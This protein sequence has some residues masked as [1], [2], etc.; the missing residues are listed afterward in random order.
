MTTPNTQQSDVP[1]RWR[2]AD[3]IANQL[4]TARLLGERVRLIQAHRVYLRNHPRLG[5]I[6]TEAPQVAAAG[7]RQLV[8]V[9]AI[10]AGSAPAVI[11][12]HGP[13]WSL[14]LSAG[15]PLPDWVLAVHDAY[16]LHL[17]PASQARPGWLPAFHL[18]ADPFARPEL[19]R[20]CQR[21][22]AAIR[23]H[24]P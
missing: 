21:V 18:G 17:L 12:L 9:A 14:V 2:L 7:D 19:T 3:Q 1:R 5:E 16:P 15:R 8:R 6:L 23:P 22:H 24:C 10:I 13:A 11:R 4:F 20:M